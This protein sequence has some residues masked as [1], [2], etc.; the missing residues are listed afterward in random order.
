M[1]IPGYEL[2]E[3]VGEGSMAVVWKA[4]QKSLDRNVAIK[5]LKAE[6]SKD[7]DEVRDFIREARAAAAIKHGNVIQVIDIAQ[8]ESTFYIVMEMIHGPSVGELLQKRGRIPQKK[9]LQVALPVAKAL[10][11]AW[12]TKK[13]IHRDIKPHNI[14][15]DDDGTVKLSDLSHAKMVGANMSTQLQTGVLVGTPNYVSP[16]QVRC[17]E[18]I[19]CRADMYSLGASIYHMITGRLPFADM[20]TREALQ[21]Q[22]EGRLPN[23]RDIVPEISP[24]VAQL[25]AKLM[26]KDPSDRYPDWSHAVKAIKRVLAGHLLISKGGQHGKSTISPPAAATRPPPSS[27]G[28]KPERRK[29]LPLGVHAALWGSLVL[30]WAAIAYSRL[31]LPPFQVIEEKTAARTSRVKTQR[32][33]TEVKVTPPVPTTTDPSPETIPRKRPTPEPA[34]VVDGNP[35]T[36]GPDSVEV[37]YA[38]YDAAQGAMNE[39]YDENFEGTATAIDSELNKAHSK[40]VMDALLEVN[41]LLPEIA[42]ASECIEAEFMRRTGTDVTIRHNGQARTVLVR[43]VAAGKINGLVETPSGERAPVTFTISQLNA[44]ERARWMGKTD[45]EAKAVL[46]FILFMKDKDYSAASKVAAHCGPLSEIFRLEVDARIGKV[47]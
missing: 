5:I 37:T 15:I 18:G 11:H 41:S 45:S 19:D 46:Q 25:V 20:D 7:L 39:L 27:A 47:Q 40:A 35:E 6:L 13:I 42:K 3:T 1:N 38:L 32:P 12:N 23:P 31:N 8:H 30:I 33:D 34:V 26:M 14:L 22:I 17:D 4:H 28:K 21:A 44:S 10:E 16:E 43:S 29:G 24:G 2:L 9:A 36:S